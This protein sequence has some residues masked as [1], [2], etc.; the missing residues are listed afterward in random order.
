[1]QHCF[2]LS[3][4]PNIFM[5]RPLWHCQQLLAVHPLHSLHH[6]RLIRGIIIITASKCCHSWQL[7]W[8]DEIMCLPLVSLSPPSTSEVAG[9]TTWC[10]SWRKCV[11][12]CHAI[13]PVCINYLLWV[14]HG[15]KLMIRKFQ[16]QFIRIKQIQ[17]YPP[18]IIVDCQVT[19]NSPE[20][21]HG[22]PLLV[23]SLMRIPFEGP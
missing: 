12:H 13:S 9:L 8:L 11:G 20:V 1:M 16:L 21:G 23:R 22:W 4:P 2:L 5:S 17:L 19:H 18:S 7:W 10:S 14:V 3:G 6:F 15:N